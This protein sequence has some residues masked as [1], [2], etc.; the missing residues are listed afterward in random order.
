MRPSWNLD[1]GGRGTY[2]EYGDRDVPVRDVERLFNPSTSPEDVHEQQ[3]EW[4]VHHNLQEA[5]EH[6]EDGAV[7]TVA[8]RKRIPDHDHRDATREPDH[9]HARAVRGQVGERGPREG[10]HEEGRNDP[11][12]EEREEDVC[13][14]VPGRE[15]RGEGFVADFGEDWPHHDYEA[16]GDSYMGVF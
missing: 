1:Q 12:K 16:Y 10:E 14:R 15:K 9:D 8:P 11:V 6:Y 4:R 3:R 2:D 7:L 5:V 13:E